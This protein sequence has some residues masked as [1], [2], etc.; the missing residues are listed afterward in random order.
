V[1]HEFDDASEFCKGMVNMVLCPL[2]EPAPPTNPNQVVKFELLK[3]AHQNYE[4]QAKGR[5]HNSSRV[6]FAL[7]IGQ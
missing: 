4:K 3:M 7:I 5:Q 2:D 6:L 1:G